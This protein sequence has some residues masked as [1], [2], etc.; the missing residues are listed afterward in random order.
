M[1]KGLSLARQ[2]LQPHLIEAA[3][4]AV[5]ILTVVNYLII[6]AAL[7]D[8]LDPVSNLWGQW[9]WLWRGGYTLSGVFVL[10]GILAARRGMEFLGLVLLVAGVVV[11][12]IAICAELPLRYAGASVLATVVFVPFYVARM[13]Q[14]LRG[15]VLAVVKIVE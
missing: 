9:S 7:R 13:R 2:R 10:V 14:I 5:T 3:I 4:A 12:T 15:Q 1:K 8:Q 6:P 11:Q